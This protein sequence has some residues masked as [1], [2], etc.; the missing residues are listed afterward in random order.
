M[1]LISKDKVWRN[2]LDYIDSQELFFPALVRQRLNPEAEEIFDEFLEIMKSHRMIV[3]FRR[4]NLSHFIAYILLWIRYRV[5][6]WGKPVPE[7]FV[8]DSGW[9]ESCARPL[10]ELVGV[11][12]GEPDKLERG[13]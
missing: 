11:E 3:P 12:S 6:R 9:S 7:V 1:Q 5:F 13:K 8:K 4:R 10:D 2:L